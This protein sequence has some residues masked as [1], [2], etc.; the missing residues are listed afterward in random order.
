[1]KVLHVVK[2]SEGGDW[3]AREVRELVSNG[4]QMHV[5][6]PPGTE[7]GLRKWKE[8]GATLHFIDLDFPALKPWLLPERLSH[9]RQLINAVSPD[10]IHSHFFGTT[11]VLRYALGKEHPVARIFQIP[12]PLHLEQPLFRNWELSSAGP[13]DF[14]I[15]SSQYIKKLYSDAGIPEDRLFQSYYG[16]D[17]SQKPPV[18]TYALHDLLSLPHDQKIIGNVSHIYKPKYYLGQFRGIK[19]HEDLIE[20]LAEVS[21]SRED[22][23][24]ILIGGAWKGATRYERKLRRKA[25]EIGGNRIRMIGQLEHRKVLSLLPDFDIVIHV[26][27]SE[28]C[29]GVVE[30]LLAGVPVIASKVGGLQE[31]VEHGVTGSLV[32]PADPKGLA[33]E[34]SAT[35]ASMPVALEQAAKGQERARKLFDVKRTSEE[36][37]KIYQAV[38]TANRTRFIP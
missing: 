4:L 38:L 30:P 18:R 8:T 31:V 2:T 19:G 23:T 10:L 20:A 3:A 9:A 35:L 12:G 7:N 27:L 6:V 15:P 32:S 16:V 28:N 33:L 34:I 24:G 13:A 25:I 21:N 1:M 36:V 26:P 14:W 37:I 5:A 11:L 29:G 17:L 22:V